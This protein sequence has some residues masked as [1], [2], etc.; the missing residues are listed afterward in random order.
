MPAFGIDIGYAAV[1]IVVINDNNRVVWS[2]YTL[3]H[4]DIRGVVNA[5]MKQL[6]QKNSYG[7]L[8][9][10]AVTGSGQDLVAGRV[11]AVN[12]V[13]AVVAAGR[14]FCEQAASVVEI[15]AQTAKYITGLKEK[16]GRGIKVAMNANCASGT[17]AFLDEQIS[18]LDL[19]LEDF[20][21][22]AARAKSIPRIAGRCGVFAKTD[23]THHQQEGVPVADILLA[24]LFD[25]GL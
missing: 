12:E 10:G 23:I 2:D 24:H 7:P 14:I 16:A 13:A 8:R 18:R 21:G 3:H 11:K 17:G 15:G 4:G 1:K 25:M 6:R 22:Y 9:M 20:S 5:R 19:A